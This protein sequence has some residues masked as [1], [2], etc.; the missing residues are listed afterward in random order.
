M[1]IL[2]I[3]YLQEC[4]AFQI[5]IG[6]KLCN[7]ISLYQSPSQTIWSVCNDLELT[8]DEEANHILFLKVV[9]GDFNV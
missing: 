4:I 5:L 3:K 8:L 1:K 2:D 9:L 6:N 7:F